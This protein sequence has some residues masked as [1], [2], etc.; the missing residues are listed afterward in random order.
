MRPPL[1]RPLT[2][3]RAAFSNTRRPYGLGASC[4]RSLSLAVAPVD[5][6]KGVIVSV[7]AVASSRCVRVRESRFFQ[8]ARSSAVAEVCSD[9]STWKLTVNSYSSCG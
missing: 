2:L 6:V 7:R 8:N 5:P 1:D 9:Y 4:S 3:K